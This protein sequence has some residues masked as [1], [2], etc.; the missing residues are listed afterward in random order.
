M[1]RST[2]A[3]VVSIDEELRVKDARAG[4]VES[5]T[6]VTLRLVARPRAASAAVSR[7]SVLPEA[8]ARKRYDNCQVPAGLN[9]GKG[10]TTELLIRVEGAKVLIPWR[11]YPPEGS[12]KAVSR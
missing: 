4:G 1:V 9:R 7:K 6:E 11:A 8:S 2:S 5:T 10:I 3:A 12:T